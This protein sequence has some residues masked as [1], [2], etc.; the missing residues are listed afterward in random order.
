VAAPL[1]VWQRDWRLD[2]DGTY[3]GPRWRLPLPEPGLAGPYQ[4]V[5]AATALAALETLDDA[6][7]TP[8]AAAAGIR[9]AHWPARL[10]D[11]TRAVGLPAG[12]TLWLDGGHNP[13]A[14]QALSEWARERGRPLHLVGAMLRVKDARG[15]L[16]PLAPLA[17]SCHAVP[18]PAGHDALTPDELAGI[19]ADAGIARTATAADWRAALRAVLAGA[20]PPGD[21]LI[22]GSLYLAGQVLGDLAAE[23]LPA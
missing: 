9:T 20:A 8:E 14:G 6:L 3:R 10:Q 15:F 17:R 4:R 12:W 11:L 22:C 18:M 23:P 5:N 7:V 19:A 13:G 21:I 16:A 2:P 1:L